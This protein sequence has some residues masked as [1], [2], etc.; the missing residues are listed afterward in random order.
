MFLPIRPPS[1]WVFIAAEHSPILY[2]TWRFRLDP[3]WLLSPVVTPIQ[4][5]PHK[6]R[7]LLIEDA[8][9]NQE[10]GSDSSDADCQENP[11]ATSLTDY[12]DR[13]RIQKLI[14]AGFDV[15]EERIPS[16]IT[17]KNRIIVAT[18][19]PPKEVINAD[20]TDT[21]VDGNN[22]DVVSKNPS[23][24]PLA[25]NK[26]SDKWVRP[27]KVFTIPLADTPSA[28]LT[29]ESQSGRLAADLRQRR[30]APNLSLSLYF[31]DPETMTPEKLNEL[32]SAVAQQEQQKHFP[33]EQGSVVVTH[34][35]YGS[36]GPFSNPDGKLSRSFHICYEVTDTT[37]RLPQ[38]T[39]TQAKELHKVVCQRITENALPSITLRQGLRG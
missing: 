18:P 21:A 38:V 31:S 19:P 17:P 35:K 22:N 6:I 4:N 12:I 34:V 20:Q 33:N 7:E 26:A 3:P 8:K 15:Q 24:A 14:D 23:N 1:S 36:K 10:V 11:P 13:C 5:N 27:K 16:V 25:T 28:R 9:K 37:G 30:P 29:V 2:W 32:A 39:K